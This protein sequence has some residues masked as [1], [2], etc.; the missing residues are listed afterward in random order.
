M[1]SKYNDLETETGFNSY[2]D[3]DLASGAL[4]CC[5]EAMQFC[6]REDR[7]KCT[8]YCPFPFCLQCELTTANGSTK[9]NIINSLKD[10]YQVE[11]VNGK[12]VVK[13]QAFTIPMDIGAWGVT[14]PQ[15]GCNHL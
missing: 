3:Q 2:I 11:L 14:S 4:L 9:K 10:G 13:P 1:V 8:D 15:I 5:Q 12:P 7:W 6:N